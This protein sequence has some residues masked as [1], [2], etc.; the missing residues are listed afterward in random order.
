MVT[1]RT[2]HILFGMFGITAGQ[3]NVLAAVTE[4]FHNW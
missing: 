2:V 1:L 3:V 4:Y